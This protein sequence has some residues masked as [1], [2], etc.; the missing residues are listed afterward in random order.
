MCAN[1]WPVRQQ[2]QMQTNAHFKAIIINILYIN[3]KL[4]F[5]PRSIF[6]YLPYQLLLLHHL[7]HRHHHLLASCP[8]LPV[9]IDSNMVIK[10]YF[11][12]SNVSVLQ[13]SKWLSVNKD[14]KEKSF[15]LAWLSIFFPFSDWGA[16][17]VTA[18][19]IHCKIRHL[20]MANEL[21][22][23]FYGFFPAFPV[24]SYYALEW[25]FSTCCYTI[26]WVKP[27]ASL[28]YLNSAWA[29]SLTYEQALQ[30]SFSSLVFVRNCIFLL[31]LER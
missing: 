19:M 2:M 23:Y 27:S 7:P 4:F 1:D 6:F 22:N 17:K 25:L 10:S 11:W 16:N 29:S 15:R 18:L 30:S 21:Q 31:L 14:F 20:P 26:L 13:S 12:L 28:N 3:I 9:N 8:L 24:V 5:I